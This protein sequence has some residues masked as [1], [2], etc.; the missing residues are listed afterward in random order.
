[1]VNAIPD[2]DDVVGLH[3]AP[4]A[5]HL[6]TQPARFKDHDL[7]M[8]RAMKGNSGTAIQYQEANIDRM[9][10]REWPHVKLFSADLAIDKQIS[11]LPGRNC[12][13][14]SQPG[15]KALPHSKLH[16]PPGSAYISRCLPDVLCQS[17]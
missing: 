10:G 7:E 2:D 15:G 6:V 14:I 5:P 11:A 1:M 3:N 17:E 9:C 13:R 8:V 12:L 4:T 16:G